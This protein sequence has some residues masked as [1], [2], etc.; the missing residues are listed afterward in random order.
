MRVRK[1]Q[2]GFTIVELLI[3]VAILSIVVASVCGFILVGSNSYAAANSDINVQ[4]SAQLALNQMSDVLIDTTRSVNYMGYDGG[5]TPHKALKDAEFTFTPEDKSLVMYNGVVEENMTPTGTP[6]VEVKE[7]NGNKH[8]HFYWSKDAEKLYYAELDV[9]PGDVDTST[10]AFP[11][12]PTYDPSNPTALPAGWVELASHVTDFSVDLTQVEEKRVVMLALTFLD[13]KKEYVT[14]NNVTIRNRVAVNDAELSP[15]DKKKSLAVKIMDNPIVEPGETFH[16]SIPK[17]TGQNVADK[18]V[19]W[20]VTASGSPSGGTTFTDPVNGILK[21]AS[22]EPAGQVKV[23]VTTNAKDSEGKQASDTADVE[24]KRV[25]NLNLST[26]APKDTKDDV[27]LVEPGKTYT[28]FADVTGNRLEE[29]CSVCGEDTTIDK[30]VISEKSA[31]I[32][33]EKW[34]VYDPSS[35]VGAT[36]KWNPNEFVT[37]VDSA[38][39]H[40]TFTVSD[41][42]PASTDSV[43]YGFVVQGISLLSAHGNSFG[44]SYGWVAEGI[45]F[46]IAKGKGN[47][48][49]NGNLQW[50]QGTKIGIDYPGF[51]GSG[52]GYYLICAR[53]R[54]YG[55]ETGEKVMI[56]RTLGNDS[57]V[58]P[59]LF[60]VEDISKPW[61][62]SLQVIDPQ[63]HFQ[64]GVSPDNQPNQNIRKKVEEQIHDQVVLDV[65]KDY[66]A[67]SPGGTYN[68][69]YPHTDKFEGMINPPEIFYKYKGQTNLSGKLYLD[70]VI[71][72]SRNDSG[73]T[74]DTAFGVD[75]VKN[76][77]GDSEK[78][79]GVEFANNNVKFS[80]YREK[81]G[82]LEKIYWYDAPN[83][84][85]QGNAEPYN[86]AIQFND[87]QNA[88]NMTIKLNYNRTDSFAQAAGKYQLIPTLWYAQNPH[89]DHSYDIY[90]LDYEPNY[91]VKQYYEVPES[92]IYYEMVHGGN[93]DPFWSYFDNRFTRG[94]IY[95]P[96]PSEAR[97]TEYFDREKRDWQNAKK[98]DELKK[99]IIGENNMTKYKSSSMR[100]RYI[101]DKDK[102]IYEL[103]LFYNYWDSTWGMNMQ[104]SAGVFQCPADGNRWERKQVGPYDSQIGRGEKP[105]PSTANVDFTF[106]G[107]NYKGK[108]YI[109]L[110][111]ES[112][113]TNDFGFKKDANWQIRDNV[114]LKYQPTGQGVQGTDSMQLRCRY[115]ASQDEYTIQI[116]ERNSANGQYEYR[117]AFLCKSNETRWRQYGK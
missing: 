89:T 1:D 24:I 111:S 63:A 94:E 62:L 92:T 15:L 6:T 103:E 19:T 105:D 11:T 46:R 17:V 34:R 45:S 75:Y 3:A 65:I 113:F 37:I 107:K 58:T 88:L 78:G 27:Y 28:V 13:G 39:D 36:T 22:D 108:M 10:I 56:Y 72:M 95:F 42:A 49:V 86:Q 32:K 26:D 33:A 35:E 25:T 102:K 116:F 61:Y 52:Q 29:V 83:N 18:S 97:F 5:G 41:K 43:D 68:G 117:A 114:S 106:N 9:Q 96:T 12:P 71:S 51:N 48:S 55:S 112:A 7:G 73:G 66:L 100:C 20:S 47:I 79:G 93:V 90:Y 81:S 115:E 44:R 57:W 74:L 85:Y 59:D 70:K 67:N 16:F 30:Q 91:G 50:G 53:I 77:K 87:V 98:Q 64:P 31:I 76:T 21:V 69:K 109:P 80:V 54:E 38:P 99:T 2:R 110:P 40:A 101:T 8:Y 60:G 4:Q 14:S 82:G 84:N 23:T 104:I